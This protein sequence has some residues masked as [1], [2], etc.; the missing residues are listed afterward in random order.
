MFLVWN[1]D[2]KVKQNKSKHVQ[3]S[4]YRFKPSCNFDAHILSMANVFRHDPCYQFEDSDA[5]L[6][7]FSLQ[8]E[9]FKSS[10][11]GLSF[12]DDRQHAVPYFAHLCEAKIDTSGNHIESE[13][14]KDMNRWTETFTSY[15]IQLI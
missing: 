2:E 7:Y 13:L 6:A 11:L 4:E 9:K 14:L 3:L 15:E 8:Y 1:F 12:V 10:G 5:L